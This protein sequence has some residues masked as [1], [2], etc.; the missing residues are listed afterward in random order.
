MACYFQMNPP[1]EDIELFPIDLS[2]SDERHFKLH[3]KSDL[4][5]LKDVWAQV[6][7]T[8]ILFQQNQFFASARSS[9]LKL[10]QSKKG[11]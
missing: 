10:N 9:Y 11:F 3:Q 2:F 5:L 4:K 1:F 6:L 7:K 8:I